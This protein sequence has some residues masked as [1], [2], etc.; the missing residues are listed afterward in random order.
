ML[1]AIVLNLDFASTLLDF[2]GA[3]ILDDIQGQSFKTI[4]TGASPKNWRNSMYYRFHEEGY[5]IG[6]HEGEGVRT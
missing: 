3:P 5:G 1:D 6:P 4:T 2:A